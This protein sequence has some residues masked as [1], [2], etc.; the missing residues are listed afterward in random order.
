MNVCNV[1]SKDLSAFCNLRGVLVKILV[2]VALIIIRYDSHILQ[3]LHKICKIL[4][5]VDPKVKTSD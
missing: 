2:Q 3:Y 4:G 1:I 5:F